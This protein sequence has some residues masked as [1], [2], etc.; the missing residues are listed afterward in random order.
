MSLSDTPAHRL[1]V[2]RSSPKREGR[3]LTALAARSLGGELPVIESLST[4]DGGLGVRIRKQNE[5]VIVLLWEAA[6]EPTA[7]EGVATDARI[8]VVRRSGGVVMGAAMLEGT[9]LAVDAEDL[10]FADTPAMVGGVRLDGTWRML[11]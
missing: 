2:S 10:L 9:Q 4:L 8:A 6:N 7:V 5:E 1:I 3:F 11:P